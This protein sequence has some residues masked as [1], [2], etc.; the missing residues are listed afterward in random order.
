MICI[1]IIAETEDAIRAEMARAAEQADVVELRMDFAPGV[2]VEDVLRD[3]PCPVII[4]NR[5]TREGGKYEGSEEERIALLQRAIDLGAEYVDVELDSF[6]KI[7]RGERTRIIVSAHNFDCTPGDLEELHARLVRTG[8]DIAKFAVMTGDIRDCMCIFN[9]LKN[10]KH[11]TIAIGMG[12]AGL[13]TRI[14]GR[15]WGNFLTFA[16]LE[17]GKESAPGQVTVGDLRDLY[18]YKS[19]GPDTAAYGVI[20]NPV[21]HSMSPAIMNAAFAARD[22]DAVYLFLKVECDVVEFVNLFREIDMQGYSVTIPHKQAI[23]AAM[24]ELDP[25]VEKVGAL[26]TVANRN[27]KL[28]GTNTD[29]PGACRA[30][31]DA[32]GGEGVLDGKRVL[33]LGAG[34]AARALAYGLIQR[35]ATVAIANRTHEKAVRLAEEVDCDCV[36]VADI[37]QCDADVLLN[38]TSVGMHPN[39]DSTPAPKEALKP[40]M[41]AFDAVYNP[42]ETRL[43]R[44]ANEAGCRT[45]SG[46]A[47]FVN[48]AALQFELWTELP[49][50]RDVM[51]QVVRDRLM[52]R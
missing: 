45:V 34:G 33:L 37:A 30:L 14:L 50:P 11:P 7:R 24:D 1:P 8:A 35:G 40:G 31:E 36:A 16:S 47:W 29:V 3:R 12:E 6:D 48:Q 4:T 19:I 18:R 17:S 15:K 5:P 42:L 41:V 38:T 46:L 27:G 13:I 52:A 10:T 51:E 22:L 25:I 23:M 2:D 49:A 43:L 9:V 28:Y 39:V 44:E 26:N 32:L 21:A 20:A